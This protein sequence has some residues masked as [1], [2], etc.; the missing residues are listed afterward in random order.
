MVVLISHS[1]YSCVDIP[2]FFVRV[3]FTTPLLRRSVRSFSAAVGSGLCLFVRR[4]RLQPNEPP[5]SCRLTRP[6]RCQKFVQNS[7]SSSSCLRFCLFLSSF[8][9][10]PC[11]LTLFPPPPSLLRPLP[12]LNINM[13][14]SFLLCVLPCILYKEK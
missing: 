9:R 11:S 2:S 7:L 12:R 14:R 10:C 8:S 13:V 5:P 4:V 1:L 6:F 3:A